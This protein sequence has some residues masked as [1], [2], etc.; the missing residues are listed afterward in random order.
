MSL[1]DT[2]FSSMI[3]SILCVGVGS[4]FGGICRFLCSRFLNAYAPGFF[5]LG[6]FVVNILGCF[7]IG[8]FYGLSDHVLSPN[9]R[10]LLTVGFCGGF[11][12]F[13][14]FANEGLSFIKSGS[15]LQFALYAAL[16]VFVGVIAVYVGNMVT[17]LF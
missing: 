15:I 9:A 3:P 14:T 5:P 6:T 2:K 4:F 10:L 11:T 7:L 8:L 16:S 1:K 12:T 13:S 17:R